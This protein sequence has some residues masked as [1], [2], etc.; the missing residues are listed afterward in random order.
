MERFML[1]IRQTVACYTNKTV[2]KVRFD[3]T[4]FMIDFVEEKQD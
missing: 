2:C 4:C 1:E 3:K